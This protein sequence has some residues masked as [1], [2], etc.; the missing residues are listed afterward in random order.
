MEK[1]VYFCSVHSTSCCVHC[2]TEATLCFKTGPKY[3]HMGLQ[4]SL[5]S[6]VSLRYKCWTTLESTLKSS[7]AQQWGYFSCTPH[8]TVA[9]RQISTD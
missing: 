2:S 5:R 7:L 9:R 1:A 8:A 4:L 6:A 3:A